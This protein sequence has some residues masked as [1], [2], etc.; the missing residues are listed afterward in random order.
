M[1]KSSEARNMVDNYNAM[2]RKEKI[3]NAI[4]Y[5]NNEISQEIEK[6]A[7]VGHNTIKIS[8]PANL[9]REIIVNYLTTECGYMV[10][11]LTHSYLPISW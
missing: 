11:E 9:D 6:R 8:I 7:R 5:C 1:I 4:A 10:Y 2:V 3:D